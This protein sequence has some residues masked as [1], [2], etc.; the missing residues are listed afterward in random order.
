MRVDYLLGF[1]H[2]IHSIITFTALHKL[3]HL[4]ITP[5]LGTIEPLLIAITDERVQIDVIM[6]MFCCAELL[7]D[8]YQFDRDGV[9]KSIDVDKPR[10]P[11]ELSGDEE[12]DAAAM[13][14]FEEESANWGPR[15]ACELLLINQLLSQAGRQAGRQAVRQA[16]SKAVRQA[17][18]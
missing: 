7:D 16:G 12:A 10:D 11:P 6:N 3:S 14:H 5:S 1:D 4:R 13:A 17:G 15:A 18:N 8:S 2:G 9:Y